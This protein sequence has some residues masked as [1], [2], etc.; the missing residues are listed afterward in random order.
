MARVALRLLPRT[1]LCGLAAVLSLWA[2]AAHAGAPASAPTAPVSPCPAHTV[3]LAGGPL[4]CLARLEV[5]VDDYAACVAAGRCTPRSTRKQC[6]GDRRGLGRH[7][8]NCVDQAQA[9]RYCAF[10]GGRLPS[11]D[12]WERAART[13]LPRVDRSPGADPPADICWN[14]RGDQPG[15]CEVGSFCAPGAVCDLAGNVA[16]WTSTSVDRPG[17]KPLAIVRGGGWIFDPLTYAAELDP[18]FRR[19]LDPASRLVDLGFRCAF[20]PGAPARTRAPN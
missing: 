2:G 14:E 4:L 18:G 20:E 12:E 9:A 11:S 19:R 3:E 13:A 6:N 8:A 16:E 15:T 5:T 1:A 17:G 7:P 10:A